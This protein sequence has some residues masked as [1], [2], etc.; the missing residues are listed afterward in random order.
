MTAKISLFNKGIYKSTLRRYAWGSVLYFI[1]LF[2]FTGMSIMLTVDKAD[3]YTSWYMQYGKSLILNGEF[4]I[5]PLLLSIIVPTVAGLLIFRFIHSGKASVFVH[6]LPVKRE[7]NFISSVLAGLT[8]MAVPVLLNGIILMLISVCGYYD[9]FT[10]TD[11]VIWILYNFF[12]IFIMFSGVCFVSSITGNSFAMVVLNILFHTIL[13]V[14]SACTGVVAEM[15]LYGFPNDNSFINVVAENIFPARIMM[16]SDHITSG[17]IIPLDII[18]PVVVA[19]VFY[20]AS[21][22]LYKNRRI[23]TAEDVAGFKC[24]NPVFKYLATL[25]G[26]LVAFAAGYSFTEKNLSAFVLLVVIVSAL[27]YFACE[28]LLKKTFRVWKCYKGYL[29]FAGFF[30]AVICV[31]AFSGFFGYEARIPDSSHVESVA[32]YDYYTYEEPFV[33]NPEVI[34]DAISIHRQMT[35]KISMVPNRADYQHFHIKYK[36]KN[37]GELHRRYSVTEEEFRNI[38]SKLYENT[39]YK[40]SAEE[41]FSNNI[42]STYAYIY[43]TQSANIDEPD[44][45]QELRECI[46]KDVYEL[47][48]EQLYNDDWSFSI[49]LESTASNENGETHLRYIHQTINANFK[50][51]ID[52]IKENGYWDYVKP[53]NTDRVNHTE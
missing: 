48:Y 11:C 32:V 36:L 28:M 24:L 34:S 38:M 23:E 33:D 31:F 19:A 1:I 37:G 16:L 29:V 20:V 30:V 46:K 14:I 40:T 39:D 6:S 5:I 22:M 35:E 12:S 47:S 3:R 27:T 7:A 49:G 13:L 10:L 52:W 45:A 26:A 41:I 21:V 42:R 53:E 9:F 17:D 18:I 51:T 15:F 43:G 50:N 4:L 44:K 25:T 2:M 8:L